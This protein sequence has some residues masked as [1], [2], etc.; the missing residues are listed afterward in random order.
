ML[1][2]IR[3]RTHSWL[4]K[5]IFGLIILVFV[6][7]GVGGN[8]QSGQGVAAFVNDKPI[9]MKDFQNELEGR[10]RQI[11]KMVPGVSSED[12]R[13]FRI[14]QQVLNTM[15]SRAVME[16]EAAR[17]GISVTPVELLKIFSSQPIFQG[18]DGKFSREAYER[19]LAQDSLTAGEFEHTMMRQ[20]LVD[21]LLLYLRA[22]VTVTPEDAKRRNAFQ[23]E[24]RAISYVLFDVEEYRDGV[25]VADDAV[26]AFYEGNQAQFAESAAVSVSFIEITPATLAPSMA[27]SDEEI[28][29]A[30][31]EGPARYNLSQIL[32]AVPA[33][34]DEAK[35][36]EIRGKIERIAK[37]IQE[38][39]DFAEAAR[40]YSE[41]P[42]AADG[43]NLGWAVARQLNA[44][45]L[46]ALAGLEKGAVTKPVKTA[47][48]LALLRLNESDPDWTLAETEIKAKFRDH[49]AEDKATLAFGD[50]QAQAEDLV[51]MGKPLSEIAEAFK[52][53][54][55]TTKLVPREDLAYVLALRKPS[56][57]SLFDGP[58]GALVG[59]L[60]E[61][62]EGFVIAEIADQKPAGVKPL[63]E[64][65]DLIVDILARREAE[66]RAEIAARKAVAEFTGD[67]PAA[68]KDKLVTSDIFGRQGDIPGLGFAKSLTDAVFASPLNVWLA[69]PFATPRG[70][71]IA[72]PVESIAVSDEEWKNAEGN[73]VASMQEASREHIVSVF[74]SELMGKAKITVPNP[75]LLEE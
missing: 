55:K 2:L 32:L 56:Q 5:L 51:A 47:M 31:A 34:A 73:L 20:L 7:W 9:L 61:T 58:K 3:Q 71:V 68:F 39:K 44:E 49:I 69:E 26:K 63:D 22:S 40:E 27:V 14:P 62:R 64:V 70:A 50:A 11:Q 10:R 25:V 18:E 67:V 48:G 1:D 17:L 16:Q 74:L 6:F 23:M 21:K 75:A 60:L 46:G 65:K 38:G 45:I 43:G 53:A 19:Y 66:K 12:L 72:M 41:D 54:A 15:I 33:D 28:E 29:K 35:E 36:A 42:S 57:A 13:A 52:I 24:K 59:N 8:M 30:F 37:E 4:I